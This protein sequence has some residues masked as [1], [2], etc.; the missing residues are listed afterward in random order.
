MLYY[1]SEA[2]TLLVT[3]SSALRIYERKVIRKVLGPGLANNDLCIQ[4]NNEWYEYLS[5]IGIVPMRL[6]IQQ[7]PWLH[8]EV[9]VL[10]K[11]AISGSRRRPYV[12]WKDK[13][14]DVLSSIGED[15]QEAKGTGRIHYGWSKFDTRV[16]NDKLS[17]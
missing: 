2:F 16:G 7:L 6:N 13:I 3:D 4:F 15:A 17:K 9:D 10:V 8:S 1:S 14:E 5:G 11:E 12:R